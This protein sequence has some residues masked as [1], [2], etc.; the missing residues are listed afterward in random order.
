M[1]YVMENRAGIQAKDTLK[2]LETLTK[3]FLCV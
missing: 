3:M 1:V 2:I